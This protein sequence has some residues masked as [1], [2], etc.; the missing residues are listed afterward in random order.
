M[1]G[2]GSQGGLHPVQCSA[3]PAAP[4]LSRYGKVSQVQLKYES[5]PLRN[6]GHSDHFR[7]TCRLF[8]CVFVLTPHPSAQMCRTASPMVRALG[9]GVRQHAAP[10][11]TR[12]R[13]KGKSALLAELLVQLVFIRK[14]RTSCR[15]HDGCFFLPRTVVGV[16]NARCVAA[17]GR[18]SGHSLRPPLNLRTVQLLAHK[19][20]SA[21]TLPHTRTRL[22]TRSQA[23]NN[24]QGSADGGLVCG[25]GREDGL[26]KYHTGWRCEL[27]AW[28]AS[29]D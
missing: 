13:V 10:P 21:S 24:A 20:T 5:N 28:R 9:W 29:T 6:C 27:T 15:C 25:S 2:A 12:K 8:V 22:Q 14:T 19:H 16:R 17:D 3:A 1:G 23:R 11:D 4:S 7:C 26:F 18:T